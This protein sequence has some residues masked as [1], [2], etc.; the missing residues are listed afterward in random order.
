MI[1]RYTVQNTAATVFAALADFKKFGALHPHMTK[2][3]LTD[4]IYHVM[5]VVE[6]FGFIPVTN[7]YSV[8]V[9]AS[10]LDKKVIYR[11]NIKA[12]VTLEIIWVIESTNPVVLIETIN[13]SAIPLVKLILGNIMKK[14]HR[15]VIEKLNRPNSHS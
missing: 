1:I 5:E 11:S 10:E 8:E 6:L 2:V 7:Q 15:H 14:A 9:E 3:E 12:S 13:I 4:G